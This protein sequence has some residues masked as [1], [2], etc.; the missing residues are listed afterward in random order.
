MALMERLPSELYR[1][2]QS[3][4]LDRLAI[5]VHG[6]PGYT[7]MERAGRVAYRAL[8]RHWP[9]ARCIG[10][11]CG[12]GNNA[13]DGYV[14]ARFALRDGLAVRVLTLIEPRRLQGAAGMAAKDYLELSPVEAFD[15]GALSDVDVIVDAVLGTGLDRPVEGRFAEA[16]EAINAAQPPVLAID[17]PSGIHG[18][19]GRTMG[20]A[21]R[22]QATA[23]FIALKQGLFTAD[24]PAHTGELTFSDL[25]VPAA[26]SSGIEPAA[27]RI[28]TAQVTPHLAPRQRTAHKG[29][30]GHVLIVGG[31]RGMGGAVRL[32]AEAAG[33]LGAGLVT[34]ATRPE[35]V[36][37]ILA[38]RPEVM[39]RGIAASSELDP[40]C[41]RATVAVLGPGLGDSDWSREL[42]GRCVEF[43]GSLVVDADG[44]NRLARAPSRREDWVLTPHPGEAGRLLGC[45]AADVQAD[46]FAAVEALQARFGGVI[47][48][49]GAGSLIRT[50]RLTW[51]CDRGNPGMASGGMGDVLSGVIAGL[52]AQ[53]LSPEAAA[54]SGVW[55][56]ALAADQAAG[57]GERGLLAADLFEPLRR[58]ANPR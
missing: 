22:A 28:T 44:L 38:A 23:T 18:D 3:R 24:A 19:S 53:G 16:I 47:V 58:F 7:L 45:S 26:A 42:F 48:L 27:R 25:D 30:F 37:P 29:H 57:H 36:A 39:C 34:A 14:V 31:D 43:E 17:I 2:E 52:L 15:A 41:Q 20:V 12:G 9:Q 11:I 8:R 6:I 4:E 32:A 56:H 55:L 54:L 40:L 1:T 51:L 50:T 49:K 13:G 46:R 21:V 33:R 35:H 10:V 5:D